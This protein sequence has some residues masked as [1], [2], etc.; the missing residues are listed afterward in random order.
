MTRSPR[1][2][3]AL[4][5]G[6]VMGPNASPIENLGTVTTALLG[7]M[8]GARL[9]RTPREKLLGLLAGFDAGGGA[10]ANETPA[11]K[12]W[13]RRPGA[14]P[15]EPT[16]FAAIHVYP[17]LVEALN[18]RRDWG[19]AAAAWAGPVVACAV[20][21]GAPEA[22]RQRVASVATGVVAVTGSVLAPRGWRCLPILLAVKLVHGHATAGGPLVRWLGGGGGSAA[23]ADADDAPDAGPAAGGAPA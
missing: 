21:T 5:W 8:V 22:S 1:S 18:G 20:V 16:A 6:R 12:R 10:W 3:M 19:R 7:A 23:T 17:F 14:S 15:L 4:A 13:Y 9:P 2:G 11:A